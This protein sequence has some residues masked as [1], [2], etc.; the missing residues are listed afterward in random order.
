MTARAIVQTKQLA[1]CANQPCPNLKYFDC[2]SAVWGGQ[3]LGLYILK[4]F[5]NLKRTASIGKTVYSPP[6]LNDFC[7][8]IH[9]TTNMFIFMKKVFTMARKTCWTIWHDLDFC[10]KGKEAPLNRMPLDPEGLQS[11]QQIKLTSSTTWLFKKKTHHSFRLQPVPFIWLQHRCHHHLGQHSET[12][13]HTGSC[14]C[15]QG[16]A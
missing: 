2:R 6:R 7:I 3:H 9:D 8:D 10:I 1:V 5:T 11:Q 16:W 15:C 12:L 4:A 13:P 14:Q